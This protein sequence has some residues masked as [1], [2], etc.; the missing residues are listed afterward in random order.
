MLFATDS[1]P[2]SS[3]GA[4]TNTVW[5]DAH[6]VEACIAGDEHAWELLLERYGRLIYTI[7]LR[8]DFSRQIAD[9]I[10]QEVCLIL[11]EKL[12]TL[13]DKGRLHPWIVTVTRR[14]CI[15]R[16][17]SKRPST[18]S[19][20]EFFDLPQNSE[21]TI[22]TRLLKSEQQNLL[23]QAMGG[24]DERCQQ[25][26]QALFFAEERLSYAELAQKLDIPIGSIGPMRARCLKKL[27]Q[28]ME[29]LEKA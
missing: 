6:L 1:P 10:F 26:L 3:I 12:D 9:E 18:V 22:E 4:A 13:Q 23:H 20:D 14:A 28:E 8:F 29:K 27:Y 2:A 25:L 15:Q 19:I 21:E 5:D 7:P 11:I 17:R 24:L 16:L